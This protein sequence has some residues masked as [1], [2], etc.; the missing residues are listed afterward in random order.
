MSGKQGVWRT[1][2]SKKIALVTP[3]AH[4]PPREML[5]TLDTRLH[6][7]GALLGRVDS[8]RGSRARQAEPKLCPACGTRCVTNRPAPAFDSDTAKIQPE[9]DLAS[10]GVGLRKFLKHSTHQVRRDPR[11]FVID[12]HQH[13][14]RIGGDTNPDC[15]SHRAMPDS[16]LQQVKDYPFQMCWVANDPA[17]R[18][19]V[20]RRGELQRHLLMQA[21]RL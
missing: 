20:N 15:S 12:R 19:R 10:T 3:A 1:R 6:N 14:S 4:A 21:R 9:T 18:H 11:T 2:I 7:H 16:I 13:A 5:H 17:I 8:S